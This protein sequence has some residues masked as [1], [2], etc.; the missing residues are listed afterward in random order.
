MRHNKTISILIMMIII[1]SFLE[2]LVFAENESTNTENNSSNEI[3][4]LTLNE[5]QEQVKNALEN[6]NTKL[7]FVEGEISDKVIEI[8]KMEEKIDNYQKELDDVNSQYSDL[9]QQVKESEEKLKSVQTEYNNKNSALKKRLVQLYKSDSTS[10][11]DVLVG[12]GNIV[13][14]ISNYFLVEK[15]ISYDEE[16]MNKIDEERKQIEKIN[17]EL[18]EKKAKMKLTKATAEKQSVILTNTKTILE[19][20]KSS[21]DESEN[22]LLSQ[23][24]SY[25]KQEEEINNLIAK[26]IISSI[27]ELTYSGGVMQW[28]TLSTSYITSPFGSRLHPI[29]GIVK[30]HDGI[31]IG[32]KT[33]DPI[34]A[35]ADGVIIYYT[36]MS[37][38]GNAVMIDHGVN[39]EGIKLVTLYG[40]GSQF[41]DGLHVGSFVKKGDV[42]MKVGSTGNSTGPHVHFEVRENGTPV[43]PK[44]YL[45]SN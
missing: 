22:E 17:N 4:T 6:A 35:A 20:E 32:G 37:G 29:Q 19:S 10:Y 13:D 24:D 27:Y 36:T 38:Y 8:Q 7:D 12:S 1:L 23:I 44:K 3:R 39:S 18:Q 34:Y 26:S 21:L 30:N 16:N 41:I 5:Q 14:F 2:G 40:H 31:D 45:S 28:P 9:E 33:G 25:K 43:D 11:L 42:V 15:I